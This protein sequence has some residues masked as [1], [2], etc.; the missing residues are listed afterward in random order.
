M[1]G[2]LLK[3]RGEFV[4][5]AAYSDCI[6]DYGKIKIGKDVNANTK[7]QHGRHDY[8][9]LF[10]VDEFLVLQQYPANHSTIHDVLDT[11]LVPYGGALVMN[12]VL[13]GTSSKQVYAP[14]PVTK[15]FQYRDDSPNGIVKSIVKA[16]DFHSVRNPHSVML[17]NPF[18]LATRSVT[19]GVSV[20]TTH[21]PGY[22]H[23][24]QLGKTGA[25]DAMKPSSVILVYH[26]RFLSIKEYTQKRCIRGEAIGNLKGCNHKTGQLDNN[27]APQ[28]AWH[29]PGDVLDTTAWDFLTSKVP[30][31]RIYDT[32][33]WQD[34]T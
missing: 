29:R 2:N 1:P 7:D 20:R 6:R 33:D 3:D 17:N 23:N 12:W 13:F 21:E 11:Y 34:Y 19:K 10:D 4:Q 25:S 8:F 16:T 22:F 27:G 28:H 15:R 9:A 24:E 30:K 14:V 32:E 26:Y 5:N 31:Y 18:G